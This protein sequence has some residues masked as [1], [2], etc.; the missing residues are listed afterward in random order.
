MVTIDPV[1]GDLNTTSI[2]TI[3]NCGPT[4]ADPTTTS[5]GN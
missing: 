5:C 3:G 4:V 2:T 1:T